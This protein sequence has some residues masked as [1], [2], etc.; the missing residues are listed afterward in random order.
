MSS[1]PTNAV[2]VPSPLSNTVVLAVR[3]VTRFEANRRASAGNGS[4]TADEL[5]ASNGLEPSTLP[6]SGSAG[7]GAG[8]DSNTGRS[9][10]GVDGSTAAPAAGTPPTTK[11][12]ANTDTATTTVHNRRIANPHSTTRANYA[13]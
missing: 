11:P 8:V 3:R 12:P 9:R 1:P 2:D 7:G 5:N 6:S 4:F 10:H 13:D